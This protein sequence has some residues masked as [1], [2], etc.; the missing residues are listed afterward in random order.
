MTAL[1]ALVRS[2]RVHLMTDGAAYSPGGAIEGSMSK[3]HMLAHLPAA[4]SFRGPVYFWT[5]LVAR[6]DVSG[7]RTF[8]ELLGGIVDEVRMCLEIGARMHGHAHVEVIVAGWSHERDQPECYLIDSKAGGDLTPAPD[9]Y[10]SPMEP[11]MG[12]RLSAGGW[13]LYDEKNDARALLD[14][15]RCQR[16]ERFAIGHGPEVAPLGVFAQHTVLTR[17]GIISRIV[18]RWPEDVAA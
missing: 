9:G 10:F 4:L 12:R 2:D 18:E 11:D 1:N 7:C 17:D 8:D 13:N 15:M 6:L 5:A 3:V 14:L 16:A